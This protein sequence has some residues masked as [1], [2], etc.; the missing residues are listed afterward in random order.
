MKQYRKFELALMKLSLKKVKSQLANLLLAAAMVFVMDASL[1]LAHARSDAAGVEGV[2]VQSRITVNAEGK[3]ISTPADKVKPGDLIEYQVRY[4]N[5]G[6][7]PAGNLV[8]TLPI[9]KGL[10][11]VGQTDF[12][13]AQSA[14]V[15]GVNFESAPL[16]RLVK[17]VDGSQV[18]EFVPLAE[19]RALRWQAGALAPG[20]TTIFSAR[21]TVSSALIVSSSAVLSSKQ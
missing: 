5:N 12:P 15:D 18:L 16:K 1:N 14:S 13:R 8:V 6:A 20:K 3:E 21:A 7:A 17:R 10:E 19:Y 9:P 4:V 11:Y 2:L